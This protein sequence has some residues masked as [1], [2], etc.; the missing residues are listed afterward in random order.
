MADVHEDSALEAA[1]G[2]VVRRVFPDGVLRRHS[3][4][5]GGVCAAIHALE[6]ER[7]GG[8][9]ERVV[10]RRPGAVGDA[11]VTAEEVEREFELLRALRASGLPVPEPHLVDCSGEIL[12]TPYLVVDYVAGTTEVR[13]E[14]LADALE[15]MASFL[16]RLHRLEVGRLR[17]PGLPPRD[18]PIREMLTFLPDGVPE[19]WRELLREMGPVRSRNT[20]VLLHGDFWPGNALWSQ[21]RLVGVI[22]WEDA[23][24]GEPL[25]DLAATRLEL[26]W[27]HGW[28]A[29]E[30][31][32]ERYLA[33][34]PV[35][36]RHLPLWD[37]Y[38]ASA[39][40]THMPTWRLA[41]DVEA[42]Q[43]ALAIEFSERAMRRILAM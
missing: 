2:R 7:P 40:R 41:A 28:A 23:A 18:E 14:G 26:L 1:L 10:V 16:A 21:G 35:D 17:L 15:Q 19:R 34:A 43:Q 25:S 22:D 36:V 39:A 30:D 9:E 37:L 4:L 27:E 8:R 3:R 38:V 13:P 24:L 33:R 32:T 31:L 20:R 42:R 6:V 11:G 29:S 12:A 5:S